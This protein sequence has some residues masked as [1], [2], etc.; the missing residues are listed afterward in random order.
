[1]CPMHP[2]IV[3]D[4]PGMCPECGMTLI[5]KKS[6][7]E[8]KTADRGHDIINKHEGHHTEDFLKKFWIVLA[9]TIPI[10]VYSEIFARAFAW[11]PPQFIGVQ[12]VMLALGS[13]IFFLWWFSIYFWRISRAP[14][15][16]AWNDDT[17]CACDYVGIRI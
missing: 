16:N 3:R 8:G 11:Q 13:F 7:I 12:Y 14:H 6:N 17:Y 10:L 1:M 9:L 4:M 5:V 15:K 2:N